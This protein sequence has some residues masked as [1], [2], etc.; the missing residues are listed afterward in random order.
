VDIWDVCVVVYV[1]VLLLEMV[2]DP[3]MVWMVGQWL[4]Y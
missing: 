2:V 3:L 1:P 4:M